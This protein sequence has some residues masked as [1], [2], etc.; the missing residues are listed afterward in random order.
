MYIEYL[1]QN[2][3]NRKSLGNYISA[4]KLLHKFA[5]RQCHAVDS[6]EVGL[7]M[8][9]ASLTMRGIPNQKLPL[10]VSQLE[11]LVSRCAALG[12]EGQ[13]IKTAFIIGFMA[14]LRASNLCPENST[15]IDPTRNLLRGDIRIAHPG[16]LVNVKWS[17][18]M[19]SAAQPLC[20]AI[21]ALTNKNLDPVFNIKLLKA[22]VPA[23]PEAP[24]FVLPSGESLTIRALRKTFSGFIKDMGLSAKSY[25][26]HSLRRGGASVS[27]KNCA[28]YMDIKRHGSW[29]SDAF[30]AYLTRLVPEESTVVTAL[31]S[32]MQ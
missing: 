4:V 29:N 16:L 27:L 5:D 19:Q 10:T 2:F 17:K 24:L 15:D 30:W 11:N 14:Y 7:M 9:A 26:L 12:V 1:A 32:A 3:T 28:T 20:I 18:T 25:S 6:F 23:P 31:K 13:V 21:P 8:R 22:M